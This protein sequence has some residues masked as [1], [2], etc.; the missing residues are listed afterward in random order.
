M[1]THDPGIVGLGISKQDQFN[2]R[3]EHM[4]FML[5][6]NVRGLRSNLNN[7]KEYLEIS[8]TNNI[9]I[10]SCTEIFNAC[11]KTQDNFLEGYKFVIKTNKLRQLEPIL[12]SLV[13]IKVTCR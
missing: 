3:L 11:S 4:N 9:I 1:T 10:I 6:M 2:N 12:T 8:H 7:F 13:T 5:N